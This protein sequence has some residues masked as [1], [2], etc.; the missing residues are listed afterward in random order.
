MD[1]P[2]INYEL[3]LGIA[4]LRNMLNYLLASYR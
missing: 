1:V 3:I 2:K 4:L